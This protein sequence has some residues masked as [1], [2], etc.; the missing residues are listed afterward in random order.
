MYSRIFHITWESSHDLFTLVNCLVF[1]ISRWDQ[2]YKWSSFNYRQ[3]GSSSPLT[4]DQS[5]DIVSCF[6]DR[7]VS[8]PKN[9]TIHHNSSLYMNLK[10]SLRKINSSIIEK[11]TDIFYLSLSPSTTGVLL[12]KKSSDILTPENRPIFF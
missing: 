12:N 3:N 8:L 4:W 10:I 7:Y 2:F 11:L 1:F 6:F 9:S 5:T